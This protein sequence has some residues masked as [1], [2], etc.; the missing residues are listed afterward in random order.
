M[1]SLIEYRLCLKQI[2]KELKISNGWL[3]PKLLIEVTGTPAAQR[4]AEEQA[5]LKRKA[6]KLKKMELYMQNLGLAEKHHW[7]SGAR[8]QSP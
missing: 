3:K 2:E 7:P 4:I 5:E 1:R 6:Q 8:A